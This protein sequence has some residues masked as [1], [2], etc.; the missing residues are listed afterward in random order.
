MSRDEA[1]IL[2]IPQKCERICK[3]MFIEKVEKPIVCPVFYQVSIGVLL[4]LF[5]NETSLLC[6]QKKTR[7]KKDGEKD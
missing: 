5:G 2:Q 1:L 3:R 6:E 7:R 4:A